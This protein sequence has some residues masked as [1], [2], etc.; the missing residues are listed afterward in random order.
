[1]VIQKEQK[2]KVATSP[3]TGR[4]GE[5]GLEEVLLRPVRRG[6][7]CPQDYAYSTWFTRTHRT[8]K[9]VRLGYGFLKQSG[10]DQN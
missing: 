8:Q 7:W 4:I 10:R 3:Q 6:V 1:M 9:A 2:H 5:K